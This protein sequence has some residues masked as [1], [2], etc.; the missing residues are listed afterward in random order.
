MLSLY[1]IQQHH[2]QVI[3]SINEIR[4]NIKSNIHPPCSCCDLVILLNEKD[5]VLSSYSRLKS[6]FDKP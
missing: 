1:I 2:L 6:S 4:G 5:K 3:P